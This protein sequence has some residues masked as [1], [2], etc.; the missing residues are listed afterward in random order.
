MYVPVVIAVVLSINNFIYDRNLKKQGLDIETRLDKCNTECQSMIS[1]AEIKSNQIL[2]TAN[3]KRDKI[4]NDMNRKIESLEKDYT[5]LASKFDIDENFTSEEYKNQ[6]ALL[7]VDEKNLISEEKAVNITDSSLNK[8]TANNYKKQILRCFNS[9]TTSIV[10][11]VTVKNIETMRNKLMKSYETINTLYK[12]NGVVITK[13]FLDLKLK[14]LNVKYAQEYQ[15]EQERLTQKAIREQMIEEE[16]IRKEIEREKAKIEKEETQFK[17]EI[18]KLMLRI[19][20][21][22][23]IEKQ[24]YVDKIKELESKLKEVEESKKNVL[25]RENNT[26]A[27]FVYI[28]SNI[29]SFGEDIYKIGMTRRLD[30]MDRIDELSSASVPFSFDVHAMIFS[31]DA[32]TLEATLHNIFSD[33]K[34]NKINPR[35]EFFHVSLEEIKKTVQKNFNNTVEWTDI[36]QAEQYR[37]SL[38]I[39]NNQSYAS[40]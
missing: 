10:S 2:T 13:Q 39:E 21:A 35:K 9:E 28:I 33:Y 27:G 37:Q 3:D 29:G 5:Y 1:D 30:P 26:R 34:V 6:Y 17:N 23:D 8:K 16:K 18:D 38:A 15:K 32:P 25:D 24:L 12:N 20:N 11:A 7:T 14:M 36:P 31:E 4:I 40:N 19:K 22:S